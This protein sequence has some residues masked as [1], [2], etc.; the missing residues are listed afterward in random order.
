MYLLDVPTFNLKYIL[1]STPLQWGPKFSAY[2]SAYVMK[3]FLAHADGLCKCC[4]TPMH[5]QLP[6][7]FFLQYQDKQTAEKDGDPKLVSNNTAQ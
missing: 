4:T 3:Q 2:L 6:S 5:P 7:F 1:V